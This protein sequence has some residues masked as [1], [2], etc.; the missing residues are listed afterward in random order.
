MNRIRKIDEAAC[1]NCG[2]CVDTCMMDVIRI[3]NEK[4]R[5]YIAY[6]DDCQGCFICAKDC[7]REAIILSED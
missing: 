3:N 1:I 6:P 7:P 2:V 5:V 4:G